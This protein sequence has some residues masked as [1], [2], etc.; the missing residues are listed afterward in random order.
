MSA[1]RT[2]AER[3]ELHD[4]MAVNRLSW[5]RSMAQMVKYAATLSNTEDSALLIAEAFQCDPQA[6][7]RLI[8]RVACGEDVYSIEEAGA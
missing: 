2:P 1:A 6:V 5:Q 4:R 3:R 8:G 7:E